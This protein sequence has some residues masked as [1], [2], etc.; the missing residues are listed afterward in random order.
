MAKFPGIHEHPNQVLGVYLGGVLVLGRRLIKERSSTCKQENAMNKKKKPTIE[1]KTL[2]YMRLSRNMSQRDVAK[3][4]NLSV[5]AIGH[6]E[7]GRVDLNLSR[8][9]QFLALYSY[10]KEEFEE[11]Q[12]GKPIPVLS[13]KDEC[14][15][16]LEQIDEVKLRAVHAVL[17]SFVS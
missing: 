17:T 7:H 5:A 10:T 2:R 3:K 14:I 12:A 4:F 9:D 6:F 11:Y 16:L 8:I 1:A 13:V 15:A